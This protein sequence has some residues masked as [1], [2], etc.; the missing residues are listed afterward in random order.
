MGLARP[1]ACLAALI[2]ASASAADPGRGREVYN[3]RC[4]F[5]HG[6]SGDAR[7]LAATYLEVKPRDFQ[8]ADPAQF[9]VERIAARVR[10]GVPGT[11]MKGFRGILTEQ[12][13]E[14][15]AAF[16][17]DEFV[18]KRAPNTRYHTVENGWP[19]HGRYAAAFPFA[20]G[21]IALDADPRG[22]GEAGRAGR[23][24]FLSACITCHDRARVNDPGPVWERAAR[25]VPR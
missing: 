5:C 1:L 7:T 16:V 17:R 13:V 15:V 4:Y 9:P 10:D 11:A 18:E 19:D 21:E 14:D 25:R 8:A 20:R 6:Y 12:E 3:F 23:E 2:A 22:L 24:L